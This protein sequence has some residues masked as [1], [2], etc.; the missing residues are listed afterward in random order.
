[1]N[2]NIQLTETYNW[3]A[4]Y[5]EKYQPYGYLAGVYYNQFGEKTARLIEL[6]NKM[7]ALSTPEEKE[8]RVADKQAREKS[9]A[10]SRTIW[11][12]G[13]RFFE[14]WRKNVEDAINYVD[15]FMPTSWTPGAQLG[16][17][18]F[19]CICCILIFLCILIV[20]I[21]GCK[22]YCKT[23]PKSTLRTDKEHVK[24]H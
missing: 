15:G 7:D 3:L 5:E 11:G 17:L 20:C 9:K 8:K 24:N 19:I 14:T 18:M 1:M 21:S 2:F 6:E 4:F 23:N 13:K 10:E 12:K 16:L 22:K